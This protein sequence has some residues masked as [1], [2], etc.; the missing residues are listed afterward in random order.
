[1]PSTRSFSSKGNNRKRRLFYPNLSNRSS[2]RVAESYTP[3]AGLGEK[4]GN[5]NALGAG[6]GTANPGPAYNSDLG[7]DAT[8]GGGGRGELGPWGPFVGAGCH[9]EGQE[10]FGRGR[11]SEA[12]GAGRRISRG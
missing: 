1:M 8:I 5:G 4:L 6:A 2:P 10:G 9:R 11:R 7:E 12:V 3:A